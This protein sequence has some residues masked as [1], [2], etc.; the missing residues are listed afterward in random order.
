MKVLKFGGSS[1]AS[2]S[3]V[4]QV[5][6]IIESEVDK[7]IVVVVSAL[8]GVTD[9]LIEAANQAAKGLSSYEVVINLIISQHQNMVNE[10]SMSD[11]SRMRLEES[12][13]VLYE[14]LL[15]IFKGVYLIKDLSIK[16]LDTIVSYG[17]QL[18][19]L[20]V[21]FA[22]PG[23]AWIDARTVIKTEHKNGRSI[24]H[25][26][27]TDALIKNVFAQPAAI[28]VLGGFI[29][30]DKDTG[31]N[32]NLG[33][34][35]SDYTAAL[36]AS[37]LEAEVLEIWTD[38]DGFMTADPKV[39]DKTYT[40]SE[41]TYDEATELCN[42]GAKVIYPPTIYPVCHKGIPIHVKNT[43]NPAHEGTIISSSLKSVSKQLIKGISSID[44]TSIITVQGLGMVGVIGVNYRIFKAL[45]F[46]GISVFLVSQAS[47][48]NSTSIGVRSEDTLRACKALNVEFAKEI[49][50]GVISPMRALEN[51][52]TVAVVG[53]NMKGNAGVA[54]RLF[55]TLGRNGINVVTCAQGASE[56]N[57]SLVVERDLL[58]KALNVIHDSFFLSEYKELNLF[59]C[60]VGTVGSSLLEQI[61]SQRKRLMDEQR[62]KLN[63]VG[64][65]SS[66][67]L[68]LAREGL[69]L[70]NYKE[71]LQNKGMSSNPKVL[72]KEITKMNIYN[73]VFIDCT[74]S[75][76]VADLY[77]TLLNHNISIVAANKIA[78]SSSYDNYLKLKREAL[79]KGVK[80]LFET[81]VGAGLPVINTINDLINSGDKI[82]KIEAVL[83]G[84][85]NYIFSELSSEVPLSQ[86]IRQ[87]QEKG[88]SEPDPRIDLS[89]TDV[90]R[91]LV[92]LAREAGYALEQSEVDKNIFIPNEFFDGS[93]DDFWKQISKL[94]EKFEVERKELERAEK[95]WCFVA[96]LENGKASVGLEA[97]DKNHPFYVLE[98]SNNVILLTSDRYKDYPM[99]IQGYGAGASVTAA[100]V[101]ADIMS[102]A[103][104]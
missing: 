44:N 104:V 21:S 5:R 34:G 64:I 88:Y 31:D 59:L 32:T 83:S 93:L 46:E 8:G 67:R 75:Q 47:S 60:G 24:P 27:T 102:I 62:L 97:V 45:A 66:S 79:T 54:G 9:R 95:K 80:F 84:T 69:N 56:L 10:L 41:L 51:L 6:S 43:F 103:N 37:A 85:L 55:Q 99:L 38:V 101:F 28:S 42:F 49:K 58:R 40:I 94:D 98:G 91:K 19:S 61:K 14:E 13:Q 53:K 50:Q 92:I 35:G 1:V 36:I 25:T 22:V 71:Q 63:V 33:R 74:A 29:A 86:A 11:D 20:I 48:E 68:L 15:N 72:Q 17:E 65:A 16:T 2:A 7:P 100:G 70:D 81:N 87:A 73:S 78:A 90:I 39:I 18:S 26:E 30:S 4:T 82:V 57:I 76:E 96:K 12:L 3:T 89:G 23:A 52:S 77:Y